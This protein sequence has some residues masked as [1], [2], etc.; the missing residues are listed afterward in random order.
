MLNTFGEVETTVSV[1]LNPSTAKRFNP[2][3]ARISHC[4]TIFSPP[5]RWI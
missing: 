2:S 1:K 3:I 5:I 4:A